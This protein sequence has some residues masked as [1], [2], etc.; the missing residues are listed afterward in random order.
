MLDLYNNVAVQTLLPLASRTSSANGT[1]VDIS[2]YD[3]Q[4]VA[5][6]V[7][8]DCSGDGVYNDQTF[9][10]KLQES[11]DNSTWS[12]IPGLSFTQLTDASTAGK[13]EKAVPIRERKK[14]IRAVF[15]YGGTSGG[16][17]PC[18]L[19]L[20]VGGATLNPI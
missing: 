6:L 16:S 7:Y 4:A 19:V 18:A 1:G 11:D 17:C 14:Y 12:D 9:D 13:E 2:A 3:G 20:I 15:T 10:F 5:L 8:G